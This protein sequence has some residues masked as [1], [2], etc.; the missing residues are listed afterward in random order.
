MND[1]NL[2]PSLL[3]RMVAFFL[4][5]LFAL[6][7]GSIVWYYP[8]APNWTY[9]DLFRISS[10][11][12]IIW[13]TVCFFSA[14][15]IN[16]AGKY[17]IGFKYYKR[18]V[19]L[20]LGFTGSV[21][22][23]V[24]ANHVLIILVAWL[25][26]GFF[27]SRLI[28]IDRRWGEAREASRYCQ[29]HFLAGTLFLAIG[30]LM[31]SFELN[32]FTVTGIISSV[33]DIPYWLL[34]ISAL[35]II[36][37]AAIQSAMFPFHRWLL[38][39]MTSPTP[40]SALMHA[41]FVNGAGILLTLLAPLFFKSDT[42]TLLFFIGGITA[43]VAQFAKLIQVNIK[44][45]L[46][47]STTA[48]MAFMIM[49]CGLGFFNAAVVHLILHGCYKAYL[50]L[51]SGEEIE[52]LSP[53]KPQRPSRT[54]WQTAF[55]FALGILGALFFAWITGKGLHLDGGI[56]LTLIVAIT[57]G[58]AMEN[59]I[60]RDEFSILKKLIIAPIFFL[61][62]IGL[63]ALMYNGTTIFMHDLPMIDYPES[64]SVLQIVFGVI[65][66]IGF[67]IMKL[68]IYESFPWLYVKLIND[69]Q[70]YKKTLLRYKKNIK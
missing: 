6:N 30:L 10:L 29:K 11:S 58:Q 21:S 28:G 48:Q 16:F 24:F 42:M 51:S 47:C 18:F 45:K 32:Q 13:A 55:V 33:G 68:G 69:S 8:E 35:C 40:A 59:I 44:Q 54:K 46:G 14:V 36:I 63:Y 17:L 31:L 65:F 23:L 41:G 2:R 1:Q 66:L 39:A 56:F 34:L 61:L 26:M 22:L 12:L 70:P 60:K 43:I 5:A 25:G 37:A 27:M 49:Q 7:I 4:W 62:S 57:V 19:L 52:H 64:L 50:F 53:K 3:Y 38:S 15:V 9:G 67:F 20:A